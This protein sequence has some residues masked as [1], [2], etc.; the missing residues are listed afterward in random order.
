MSM[1]EGMRWNSRTTLQGV[2]FEWEEEPTRRLVRLAGSSPEEGAPVRIGMSGAEVEAVIV[3]SSPG[4]LHVRLAK[5]KMQKA[6]AR[7]P[8]RGKKAAEK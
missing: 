7:T 1:T 8:A 4:V 2:Q 5:P 6:D 3:R